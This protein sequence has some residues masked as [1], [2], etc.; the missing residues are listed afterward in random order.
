MQLGA[1]YSLY[2]WIFV[3][4][5]RTELTAFYGFFHLENLFCAAT[6]AL[7]RR[8][9]GK[10]SSCMQRQTTYCLALVAK[11]TEKWRLK[12]TELI[13][14]RKRSKETLW[15]HISLIPKAAL[16]EWFMLVSLIWESSKQNKDRNTKCFQESKKGKVWECCFSLL[17]APN[18]FHELVIQIC[19]A[20]VFW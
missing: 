6:S 8:G 19:V 7:G 18:A 15:M 13:G 16:F 3:V 20:Q 12:K 4:S 14:G 9:S 11:E 17:L 1:R 2:S 5:N 10:P